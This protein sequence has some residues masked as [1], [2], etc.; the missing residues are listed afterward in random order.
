MAT[1]SWV[2][3][4]VDVQDPLMVYTDLNGLR[5]FALYHQNGPRAHII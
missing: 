2:Y 4:I 3:A 5:F 1:A